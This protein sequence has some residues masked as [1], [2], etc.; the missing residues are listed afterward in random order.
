VIRP[1]EKGEL[2]TAIKTLLARPETSCDE[3]DRQVDTLL[4]Y[5]SKQHLSLDQCLVAGD[6]GRIETAC[7]CVDA[8]GRTASVFIPNHAPTPAHA[9]MVVAML[10]E[11]A[12]R[13]QG[14][15]VRLM[16][17]LVAP[18]AAGERQLFERAGFQ[19]LTELIY[20]ER[21][22]T[23][24]MPRGMEYE[25]VQ[26][27]E[28]TTV[29]HEEFARVI[30]GT[31]AGSLD[32]A[33]LSGV[34]S[35]EDTLASHRAAGEFDPRFWLLARSEGVAVGALLLAR[36]AERGS[37]EVVYMGLL[38]EA[39]GRRLGV[40]L[41]RRA[42]ETARAQGAGLVTLTVDAEN[43]PAQKLYAGFEFREWSRREVW[44]KILNRT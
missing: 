12:N 23:A 44:L 40:T 41:L 15:R 4:R 28:Y 16:Q 39:R 21:D 14:R 1:A 2:K 19:R 17:G 22:A 36:I 38:P 26:W 20:L 34:R 7:L 43:S 35:I 3:L 42:V 10:G 27:E 24:P 32:C 11:A 29:S 25:P 37:M 9:E 18:E 8:P 5:A 13:A 33:A 6:R 31:Y 30:E